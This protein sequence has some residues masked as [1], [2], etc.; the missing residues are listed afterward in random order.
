M[1]LKYA[2]PPSS[3]TEVITNSP[4]GRHI[5]D[6]G[7]SKNTI[8]AIGQNLNVP[9]LRATDPLRLREAAAGKARWEVHKCL[10]ARFPLS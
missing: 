5:F 4:G 9:A 6:I 8:A 10:A 7:K 1:H 3:D 2:E